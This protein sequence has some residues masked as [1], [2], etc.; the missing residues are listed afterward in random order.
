MANLSKTSP[1]LQYARF[2]ERPSTV[3]GGDTYRLV[4]MSA[5][6]S[7]L[8]SYSN[9]KRV[10]MIRGNQEH[11]EWLLRTCKNAIVQIRNTA[12]ITLTMDELK[13]KG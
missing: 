8:Y 6:A 13:Q 3:K 1:V 7:A 5:L 9:E 12:G 2:M 4:A 10:E 11:V